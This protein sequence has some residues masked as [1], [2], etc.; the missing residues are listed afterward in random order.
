MQ[1][2]LIEQKAVVME[3]RDI[4]TVIMPKAELKLFVTAD[5]EVRA[6]R[7]QA[8]MKS[9]GKEIN[10]DEVKSN[11]AERDRIDSTRETAPLRVADDAIVIDNSEVNLEELQRMVVAL[12]RPLIDDGLLPHLR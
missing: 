4:G 7:R 2:S 10:L 9:S 12:A 3:G 5:F 8:Q 11:L 6:I 1:T